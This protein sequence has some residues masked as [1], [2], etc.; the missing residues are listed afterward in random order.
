VLWALGAPLED[1][2]MIDAAGTP[3]VVA[4]ASDEGPVTPMSRTLRDGV[5]AAVTE[6]SAAPLA[7]TIREA[8]AALAFT[9]GPVHLDLAQLD[10]REA[11]A[12]SRLRAAFEQRLGAE[13]STEGKVRVALATVGE[14]ASA[15][16]DVLRARAQRRL[17]EAE[18]EEQAEALARD[19]RSPHAARLIT[20]A[21]A[22]LVASGGVDE[23]PDVER[24]EPGDRR[25]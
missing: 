11:R 5:I 20:A 16:G 4:P 9:W 25:D 6:M 3:R 12:S 2:L 15:F 17:A 10:D 19:Q 7:S 21:A 1:H 14:I 13:P 22:N 24:D 23:E 8:S 18:P